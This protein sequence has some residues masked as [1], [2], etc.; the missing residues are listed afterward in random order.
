MDRATALEL[1]G[2]RDPAGPEE[3]RRAYRRRVAQVHPDVSDAADATARTVA[4]TEAYALLRHGP[5][6]ATAAPTASAGHAG[7][8][9]ATRRDGARADVPVQV[10]QIDVDTVAVHAPADTTLL[11]LVEAAHDLGDVVYLDP[12][13]GLVEVLVEFVEAPTCSLLLTLQGRADGTTEVWG[14][15]ET[16]SGE[17]PP[18]VGAVVRLV[19]EAL[20]AAA[21]P[22]AG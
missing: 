9:R 15:V 17:A 1:L 21:V 20:S 2:L 6:A 18:P 16:L 14:T 3:L 5:P 11:L 13:A 10:E 22:E 8:E 7:P 4:L 19:A 12:S